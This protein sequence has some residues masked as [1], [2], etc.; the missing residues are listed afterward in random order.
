MENFSTEKLLYITSWRV[1]LGQLIKWCRC[2]IMQWENDTSVRN[3]V[4]KLLQ[5]N[6]EHAGQ[7]QTKLTSSGFLEHGLCVPITPGSKIGG[8]T[9]LFRVGEYQR[10]RMMLEHGSY[11]WVILV[12][13]C[14][15]SNTL[16]V[17]TVQWVVWGFL[18][19]GF[20]LRTLLS[21]YFP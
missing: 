18:C 21:A 14:P 6:L 13:I 8:C 3:W 9:F 4:F 5:L 20:I 15:Y 12:V 7:F 1:V 19:R 17:A 10:R 2:W 16:G 11:P